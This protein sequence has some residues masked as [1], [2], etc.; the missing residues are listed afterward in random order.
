MAG[1]PLPLSLLCAV[2]VSVSSAGAAVPTFNQHLVVGT[3]PRIPSQ[4]A[5]GRCLIFASVAAMISYG[6]QPT[7]PEVIAAGLYFDQSPAPTYLWV[8]VQDLTAIAALSLDA[9]HG[10]TG[11]AVGDTF[12]VTQ[13]GASAGYGVVTAA[14]AGVVTACTFIPGQQ[15]TA[16]T[17]ANGL[18]TVAQGASTGAGLEV[19]ITAIGETALQAVTA[20]RLVSTAWYTCSV[21]GAADADHVAIASFAQ[22]ATPQMQY[23]Y[24]T[25]SPSA[26]LGTAGNVFSL[27]KAA[28]YS[29]AHGAYST[30]QGGAAPN[31]AYIAAAIAGVA[32]GLNTGLA[33]SAFTLDAKTLVGITVENSPTGTLTLAQMNT[34]AGLPGQGTGNNG[35]AY[36]NFGGVYTNYVQGVNGSGAWFDQILGLDMLA[37]DCQ[38]SVL[39][40]LKQLASIPQD[41]GGQAFILNA[42]LGACKRSAARGF[43]AGG[44]WDGPTILNLTAG[45]PVPLGYKVQSQSFAT[46]SQANRALRQGMPVYIA[47]ILAGSQQSFVIGLNVQQ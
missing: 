20:C 33:N 29:R 41:D 38:I 9:G 7:D 36:M 10:G 30:I 31:N 45:D 46:Q 42:V 8:G 22:S 5:A 17:V 4:G 44:T 2:N 23:L 12:L 19:N 35:N 16:Y 47:V 14:T 3:S 6:F 21:C 13:G 40:V 32:M 11:W 24:G 18:N 25:Q 27:I 1:Q 43:L 34:F 15:G 37:A 26:M 28:A 39:N